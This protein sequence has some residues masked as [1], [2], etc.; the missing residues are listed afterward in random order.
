MATRAS[1][2]E[3]LAAVQ[4]LIQPWCQ[5]GVDGDWDKLLSMCTDD[6]VFM[7]HGAP[8]VSGDALR[9]WLDSFPKITAMSWDVDAL[10][11]A[12]DIAFL[13]GS[14]QQTLE[15]EDGVYQV[16]GKY[17]DL[18]RREAD[19]QWRFAVVIWNENRS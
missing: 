17:C 14:V 11:E 13:R 19:G 5:A 4:N 9:P 2:A 10:E 3:T 16:D 7:P 12:E 8:P 1:H 15:T 18:M 6:V